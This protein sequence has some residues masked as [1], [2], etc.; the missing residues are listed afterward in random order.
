MLS[1]GIPCR[2]DSSS[3]SHSLRLR[4]H[5]LGSGTMPANS[6]CCCPTPPARCAAHAARQ[7][8]D[9]RRRN[10]EEEYIMRPIIP[11]VIACIIAIG[12]PAASTAAYPERVITMIVAYVPGGGTDVV[13]RAL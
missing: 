10:E 6:A 2:S 12:L 11:A 9:V 7:N 8:A 3:S 13:A 1:F 5:Y 4:L